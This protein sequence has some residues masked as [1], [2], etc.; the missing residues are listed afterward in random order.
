MPATVGHPLEDEIEIDAIL[1]K[2]ITLPEII[3]SIAT[4]CETAT[5]NEFPSTTLDYTTNP[6]RWGNLTGLNMLKKLDRHDAE[7]H[8]V[9]KSLETTKNSLEAT[10]NRVTDL[11]SEV[12]SMKG[13]MIT[14]KQESDA[15]LTIRNWF[16]ATFRRDVLKSVLEKDKTTIP[17]GNNSAHSGD[18]LVDAKFYEKN[19]RF[20]DDLF[21]HLY[22]LAFFFLKNKSC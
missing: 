21:T 11:E 1:V 3:P 13:E 6:V 22:G 5:V 17:E 14:L 9:R 4:A 16:L 18:F 19:Y 7:L 2:S 12:S 10:K 15:Y 20:D 8:F